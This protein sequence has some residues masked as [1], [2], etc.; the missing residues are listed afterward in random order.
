MMEPMISVV[1]PVY[2]SQSFIKE[3]ILTVVNQS[4]SNWELILVD[5]KSVDQSVSVIRNTIKE[6]EQNRTIKLGQIRLLEEVTNHGAYFVRNL[7]VDA[8]K[9]RYLCYLDAD[10]LWKPEKLEMQLAFMQ[11]NE[12]AFSFTSYE[13]ADTKGIGTGKVAWVPKELTYKKALKNTIIF[14]STVMFDLTKIEKE[15]IKMPAIGSEDTATWW[16]ILSKGYHAYGI[17]EVTT[18]YRRSEGTLSSNKGRGIVRIWNLYR[19]V[20]HLNVLKSS[21]YFCH[22]AVN[23]TLRRL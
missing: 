13:F 11:K 15:M 9:G 8:A 12:I 5:D 3:T 18:L 2:N 19:K 7:G 10:D 17:H 4:F 14:T 20:A 21:Y 16:K 23:A 1:I 6:L 22:F